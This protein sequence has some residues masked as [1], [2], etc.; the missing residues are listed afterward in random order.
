MSKKDYELIALV[1]ANWGTNGNSQD[2]SLMRACLA[3]G[4]AHAFE[5]ENAH[6]DSAR[7]L[8]ACEVRK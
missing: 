7:F 3:R 2:A 6:F 4:L 5:S 1:F 8:K